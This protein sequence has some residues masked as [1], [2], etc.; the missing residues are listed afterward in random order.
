M[1]L[2][3]QE[4]KYPSTPRPNSF[5]LIECNV[6]YA[7]TVFAQDENPR[8]TTDDRNAPLTPEA[9]SA[10]TQRLLSQVTYIRLHK[11]PKR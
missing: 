7:A 9:H 1:L 4:T 5:L 3:L 8:M 11:P 6:G 10:L 2:L